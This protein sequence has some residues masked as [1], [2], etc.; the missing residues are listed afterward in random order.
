MLIFLKEI[1]VA[2]QGDIKVRIA[3]NPLATS[4][5]TAEKEGGWW[6]NRNTYGKTDDWNKGGHRPNWNVGNDCAGEKEESN[7]VWGGKNR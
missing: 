1:D 3:R 4:G 7:S 5:I 6:Y 2:R